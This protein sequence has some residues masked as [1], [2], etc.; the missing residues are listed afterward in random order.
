MHVLCQNKHYNNFSISLSLT[1]EVN[2]VYIHIYNFTLTGCVVQSGHTP[3]Y[4]AILD[5]GGECL[6][7]LGDMELHNHI[8]IDLVR[9]NYII[10]QRLS[11]PTVLAVETH[12]ISYERLIRRSWRKL[13]KL[14]L[15]VFWGPLSFLWYS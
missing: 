8:S 4:A 9:I 14:V 15:V 6:L 7:G 11:V 5:A 3:T 10:S 13:I 2:K 12:S 1:N